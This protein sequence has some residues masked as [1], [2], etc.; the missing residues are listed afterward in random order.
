MQHER[1]AR[2][3]V[4]A[5]ESGDPGALRAMMHPGVELTVDGGGVVPAPP[6]ALRGAHEVTRYLSGVLLDSEVSVRI[7]SVNGMPG[8]VVCRRGEVTGVLGMRARG[9]LIV[10]AWLVVNP[11]K[12]T[13]WR[14]E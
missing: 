12:L 5:V 6:A 11:G 2:A 4:A 14:A 10:Q 8:L 9:R 1:V 13:R 3:L 7:A